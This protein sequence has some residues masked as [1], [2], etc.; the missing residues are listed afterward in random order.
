[1]SSA[2]G[3]GAK[4][5]LYTLKTVNKMGIVRSSKALRSNN[6]C[7]ACALGMGG[8]KGGMRNELGEFPSVCNKSVQAQSTD[9]QSRIPSQIFEHS[10]NELR[11]L[12]GK[13]MEHLGRLGSPIYKASGSDHYKEVGWSWAIKRAAQKLR[14]CAPDRSFF[15]SSGRASNESGFLL[16]LFAR[17][18]GTNNV[19]NCSFYCH[20]ATSIGLGS[21]IGAGTSTIALDDLGE[22]D[23]IFVI[24]ANPAS[25]H[26]RLIY[27]LKECRDRG[28]HVVVINPTKEVGLE[29]FALPK[30]PRSII[31]GGSDIASAY[32]QPKVGADLAVMKGI[33]KAIVQC[34]AEDESFIRYFT[35][36]YDSFKSDLLSVTWG[37]IEESSGLL[38]SD[39]ES[40]AELYAGSNSAVFCW[41]MGITQ[42]QFGSDNIEYIAN[43]ALLRGMIGRPGAG[44]LPLRG[45]SN[46]QGI[47]TVGVKPELSE[48][49]SARIESEFG[50]HLPKE[51]GLDTLA[52]LNAAHEGN[53]DVGVM[54]GGNLFGASP[55]A[56]WS[57]E[58]LDRIPFKLFMTTTLNKGHVIGVNEGESIVLPVL[59]RDEEAQ[60]TTQES[61]FNFVRLSDGGISRLDNL[62]SE[63]SIIAELAELVMTSSPI[64]FSVFSDHSRIRKSIASC[65]DG[66]EGLENIEETKKEF[67]VTGRVKHRREFNMPEGKAVFKVRKIPVVNPDCS[68]FPFLL[69]TIR[70]E[71]QYNTMIYEELDSYRQNAPRDAVLM[72]A[73]DMLAL[74]L[75]P[76]QGVKI[77]STNGCME[78]LKAQ[79]HS[80][81]RGSVMAYYPEANVLTG[82]TVDPRS[83]TPNFKSVPVQVSFTRAL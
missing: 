83:K 37:E 44:L 6:A 56:G 19:T 15:Y 79:P 17:L 30:S 34:G 55:N 22:C 60:P 49:L 59:A 78:N 63:V 69:S 23:L 39:I 1:M 4:K 5:I 65:I 51:S 40:V 16:Q 9:I 18:Y 74:G 77:I 12:T 33:A 80:I 2:S 76:G 57:E 3:G 42:H 25:N 8:Q 32:L 48:E 64:D 27:K 45:H 35:K 36:G 72:N 26:P 73:E 31:S 62:R 66:M 14:E 41:G 67:H 71:G 20:Q 28:G 70:S 82:N 68:R 21:T 7:K 47:G 24:G 81:P 46:V 61:M 75:E 29:R 11:E 53:I 38:R 13:E 54:V 52:S 58:A 50:V 43:L 10:I